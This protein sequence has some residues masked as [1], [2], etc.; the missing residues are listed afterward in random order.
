MK[1]PKNIYKNDITDG[2]KCMVS[3]TNVLKHKMFDESTLKNTYKMCV[4]KWGNNIE[5]T[6]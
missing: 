5:K 3:T 4:Q 6:L 1:T 2:G